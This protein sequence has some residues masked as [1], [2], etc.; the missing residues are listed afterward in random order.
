MRASEFLVVLLGFS[1]FLLGVLV[2]SIAISMIWRC[3]P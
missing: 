3:A 1:I 2:G